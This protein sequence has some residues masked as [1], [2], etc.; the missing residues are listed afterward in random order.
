MR[1]HK[2][3][4]ILSFFLVALAAQA[5]HPYLPVDGC[6]QWQ[7]LNPYPYGV[8]G[9]Q[10]FSTK[11]GIMAYGNKPYGVLSRDGGKTWQEFTAKDTAPWR[12]FTMGA[13]QFV[14]DSI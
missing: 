1:S 10:I 4:F 8:G 13:V 14:N 11:Q 6:P 5:Q 9:T 2:F 7:W 12:P 3:L